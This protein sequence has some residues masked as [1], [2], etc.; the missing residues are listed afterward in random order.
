M[1]KRKR[2]APGMSRVALAA[3]PCRVQ[4]RRAGISTW[5]A[6]GAIARS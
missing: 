5:H 3:H 4:W 1:N 2:I 6:A